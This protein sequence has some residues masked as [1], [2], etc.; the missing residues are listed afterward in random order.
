[1]KTKTSALTD[2]VTCHLEHHTQ[3]NEKQHQLWCTVRILNFVVYEISWISW[4]A[5]DP[6]KFHK[7]ILET[8]VA[9]S[10]YTKFSILVLSN[11]E[12]FTHKI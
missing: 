9:S 1:M 2:L 10:A 3:L 4:Y 8:H 5:S 6:Q 7:T 11:H 12:N